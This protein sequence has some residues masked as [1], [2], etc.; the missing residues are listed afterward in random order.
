MLSDYDACAWIFPHAENDTKRFPT[1]DFF[2]YKFLSPY[3][4]CLLPFHSL[5]A[6]AVGFSTIHMLCSRLKYTFIKFCKLY[7]LIFFNAG[8]LHFHI[9]NINLLEHYR[10]LK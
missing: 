3:N 9:K 5:N 7:L 4:D 10:A 8:L 6:Y 1:V 2:V